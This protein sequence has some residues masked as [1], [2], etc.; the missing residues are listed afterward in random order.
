MKVP[1]ETGANQGNASMHHPWWRGGGRLDVE[2]TTIDELARAAGLR[3]VRLI[4]LDLEGHDLPAMLGARE[5]IAEFRP[6]VV[7]EYHKELWR[8]A[9]FHLR[10]AER[11]LRGEFGYRLFPRRSEGGVAS[12]IGWPGHPAD[13]LEGV[14]R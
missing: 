3:R 10:D 5:T 4:K 11:M 13:E 2:V 8:R 6:L 1:M 12:V 7:F 9:G 14:M